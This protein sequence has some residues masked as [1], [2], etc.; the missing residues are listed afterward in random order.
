MY[1]AWEIELM[2]KDFIF[3]LKIIHFLKKHDTERNRYMG[4]MMR[5]T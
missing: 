2:I 5:W 1:T 3:R 4:M